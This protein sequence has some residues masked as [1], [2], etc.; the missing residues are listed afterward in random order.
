MMSMFTTIGTIQIM[1]TSNCA[2]IFTMVFGMLINDVLLLLF[3]I[4]SIK[5]IGS[6][7]KKPV[8]KVY[9]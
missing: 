8:I 6:I 7:Y 2:A 4:I 5:I 3:H 1:T 9:L